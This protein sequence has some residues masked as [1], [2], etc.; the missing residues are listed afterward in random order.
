MKGANI[1]GK[2]SSINS[3]LSSLS[4]SGDPGQLSGEIILEVD[5]GDPL[6]G[7][8]VSFTKLIS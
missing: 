5:D 6:T 4:F 3:I 2:P 8:P 1:I 7:G